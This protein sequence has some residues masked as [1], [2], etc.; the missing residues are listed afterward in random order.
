M[1]QD[2]R[3]VLAPIKL[4]LYLHITARRESG[5]HEV[6]TLIVF[7]DFGDNVRVEPSDRLEIAVEG[8]FADDLP[9]A[10]A[11]NLVL[12]ALDRMRREVG[13]EAG[14]RVTLIKNIPVAAGVGGGSSDAATAMAA[15]A[16]MWNLPKSAMTPMLKVAA[17]VGAD[18]PACLFRKPCFARGYGEVLDEAPQ[19]ATMG[20]LLVNPGIK[21]STPAVFERRRGGFSPFMADSSAQLRTIPAL[22]EFLK[23]RENDLTEAAISL[24]SP[25]EDI[26]WTFDDIKD[27]RL[28]R[29]S[30]SGATCF[31]LFDTV[32]AAEAAAASFTN[33]NWWARAAKLTMPDP[34]F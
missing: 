3:T 16:K 13:V 9:E 12:K 5:Y 7:T 31:G 24:C 20:V 28:A 21:V 27:C 18:L 29:M 14:A 11:D 19:M 34:I 30:G 25:I 15:A 1:S 33:P 4:N 32:E 10:Q 2:D 23:E 26:L 6:D 22:L 17:K 8:P